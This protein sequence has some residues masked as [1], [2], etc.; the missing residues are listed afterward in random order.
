[1]GN[2]FVHK[3]LFGS[4]FHSLLE[5]N[6]SIIRN[7]CFTSKIQEGQFLLH[8][9]VEVLIEISIFGL[10]GLCSLQDCKFQMCN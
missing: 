10:L 3:G 9:R 6:S 4:K 7:K 2:L 8:E 5:S 1:V